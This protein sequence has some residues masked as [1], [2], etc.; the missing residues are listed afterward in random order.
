MSKGL[1]NK[2]KK[3]EVKFIGQD[4]WKKIRDF[5][6][7]KFQECNSEA[8]FSRILEH[9]IAS[10]FKSSKELNAARKDFR[11]DA[12]SKR[13][14]SHIDKVMEGKDGKHKS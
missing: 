5:L 7:L 8:E 12:L 3:L 2:I 9:V 13:E 14:K 6:V 1:G 11:L 4:D 10:M